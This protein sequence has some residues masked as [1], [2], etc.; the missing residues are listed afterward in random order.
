VRA[1]PVADCFTSAQAVPV[2]EHVADRLAIDEPLTG[3]LATAVLQG[4][5]FMG[6]AGFEPATSRV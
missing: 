6:A 5:L 3:D 2:E 4:L 1:R